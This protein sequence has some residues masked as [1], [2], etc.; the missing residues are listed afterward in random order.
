MRRFFYL[1]VL[2]LVGVIP[3]LGQH[4]TVFVIKVDGAINPSSADFIHEEI[5]RTQEAQAECLII[6]LNTPGG[7]LK[8]TRVIVSDLLDSPIPII[9]YVA[10]GGSQA[11]SAA[12]PTN[13]PLCIFQTA[14]SWIIVWKGSSK[15]F[16]VYYAIEKSHHL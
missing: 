13:L 11:A 1:I 2:L 8:S 5:Q 3:L 4:N 7:L 14:K 9:V 6:E 15:S 10:P 12:I 16:V